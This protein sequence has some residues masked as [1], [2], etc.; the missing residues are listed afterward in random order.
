MYSYG[1]QL[2]Q[3]HAA[4]VC[5]CCTLFVHVF[6]FNGLFSFFM[7]FTLDSKNPDG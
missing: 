3:N 5:Q 6:K 4:V 7:L 1:L 2:A